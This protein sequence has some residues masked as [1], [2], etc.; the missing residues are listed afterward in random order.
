MDRRRLGVTLFLV[1]AGLSFAL[2]VGLWFAGNRDE[3]MF[4]GLWVPS[5]LAAGAF[6]IAAKASV[7]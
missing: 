1:A 2:S 7:G 6:W 5:I 4:V 3:G